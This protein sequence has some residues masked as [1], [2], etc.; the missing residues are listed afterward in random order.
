[1]ISAYNDD[2]LSLGPTGLLFGGLSADGLTGIVGTA[3]RNILPFGPVNLAFPDLSQVM[4]QTEGET[5]TGF[6][7]SDSAYMTDTASSN[8][9]D[10]PI[11]LSFMATEPF[12]QMIGSG[13]V[14]RYMTP[15]QPQAAS[16]NMLNFGAMGS[17]LSGASPST[18]V[19]GAMSQGTSI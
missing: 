16:Y 7:A 4:D 12:G 3:S 19:S 2:G 9:G 10:S 1:M 6:Y 18:P 17:G 15:L 13:L 14:W 11:G 8:P 5:Y